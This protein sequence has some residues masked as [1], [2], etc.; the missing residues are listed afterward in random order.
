MTEAYEMLK[1]KWTY[2]SLLN[3]EDVEIEFN[4][5]RFGAGIIDLKEI[6]EDQILDSELDMGGGFKLELQG[7]IVR[8]EG[9]VKTIKWTGTGID[10]TET[11]GWVYDYDCNLTKTW[12]NGVDQKIVLNGSVIRTVKH[13]NAPAGVVGTFYM[14][15]NG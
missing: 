8:S 3:K 15:K 7:E 5:L 12:E 14:V 1:G 2:R 4:D 6:G 10:G 13:G 9:E 11:E